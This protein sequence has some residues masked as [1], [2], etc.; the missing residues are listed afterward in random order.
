MSRLR[1]H[2]RALAALGVV[3]A[4]VVVLVI[5]VAEGGNDVR[6]PDVVPTL[7]QAREDLRDAPPALGRVYAQGPRLLQLSGDGFIDYIGRLRGYPIVIN[8]WYSTCRPCRQ[9]FPIFRRA[10]A[11][12]GTKIAFLGLNTA[13]PR[14]SAEAFLR[15]QPTVYP[16][17]R[18]PKEQI[19]RALGAGV[20][21]PTTIF[22]DR[23]GNVVTTHNGVYP[24]LKRL[25]Q[26]LRRYA[27]PA[28]TRASA[29]PS[30]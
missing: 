11:E 25:E 7:A 6:P 5:G 20:V 18:D 24:S 15:E 27:T 1:S 14:A 29:E 16:H 28:G 4:I 23:K 2:R 30:R 21:S 9:E 13:D 17:V 12:H 3:A 8:A 19:A 26:D 10:A 22:L